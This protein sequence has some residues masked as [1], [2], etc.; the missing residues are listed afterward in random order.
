MID[1][2]RAIVIANAAATAQGWGSIDPESYQAMPFLHEGK[3]AWCV[4][5]K[6]MMIGHSLWFMIDAESG[7]VFESRYRGPR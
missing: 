1:A 4:K 6:R 7:D 5:R 3:S 2:T